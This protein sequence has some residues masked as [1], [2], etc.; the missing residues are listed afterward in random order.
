MGRTILSLAEANCILQTHRTYC[1]RRLDSEEMV[2]TGGTKDYPAA[3]TD[4][5]L[6]IHFGYFRPTSKRRTKNPAMEFTDH[7]FTH[8]G[9][10]KRRRS[11][12][13]EFERIAAALPPMPDEER[14]A[15]LRE[16]AGRLGIDFEKRRIYAGY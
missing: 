15:I 2:S 1:R 3:L 7:K 6:L 11:P 13:Q 12:Q 16:A 9:A 8:Q 5:A 10:R 4:L 14:Q